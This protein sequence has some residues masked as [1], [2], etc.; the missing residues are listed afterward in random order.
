MY[1]T[2]NELIIVVAIND[3]S[4]LWNI[5]RINYFHFCEKKVRNIETEHLDCLVGSHDMASNL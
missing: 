3:A 2:I 1:N 5:A 4:I